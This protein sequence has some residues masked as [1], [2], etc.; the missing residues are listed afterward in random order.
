MELD[1]IDQIAARSLDGYLVRKDLVRTFSRQFPVPTYVVE[2]MLGRYC[3]SVDEEEINEGIAIVQRQLRSR[4]IK[5]GEEELFKSRAREN[6]RIKIID[7]IK[8]KLNAAEN[9]YEAELPSLQLNTIH[10]A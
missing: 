3:A 4:T 5:A 8:A 10:I 6:G 7:L 9:C 1:Q 2:F